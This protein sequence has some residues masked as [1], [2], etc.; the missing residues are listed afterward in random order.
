MSQD[1]SPP[2]VDVKEKK[3]ALEY[4]VSEMKRICHVKLSG[5]RNYLCPCR[6]G[7]KI[8]KCCWNLLK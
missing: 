1:P 4:Y 2:I 8:K 3:K 6:S 7:K 5:M